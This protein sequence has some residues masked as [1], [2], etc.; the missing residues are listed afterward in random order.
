MNKGENAGLTAK[1]IVPQYVKEFYECKQGAPAI[2]RVRE[3]YQMSMEEQKRPGGPVVGTPTVGVEELMD[4]KKF[5][6]R[7]SWRIVCRYAKWAVPRVGMYHNFSFY[8][9]LCFVLFSHLLKC[10]VTLRMFVFVIQ[11]G[12]YLQQSIK[13]NW[14]LQDKEVT[15]VI[16]G[17]PTRVWIED[18][19]VP[20]VHERVPGWIEIMKQIR[21]EAERRVIARAREEAPPALEDD[22]GSSENQQEQDL[23]VV[24]GAVAGDERRRSSRLKRK[25]GDPSASLN[26][27][28][29]GGSHRSPLSN[30]DINGD[31]GSSSGN[32][33]GRRTSSERS[34]SRRSSGSGTTRSDRSSRRSSTGSGSGSSRSSE[35]S[36]RRSSKHKNGRNEKSV[37]NGS[38]GNNGA[39]GSNSGKKGGGSRS[40]SRSHR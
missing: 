5:L 10:R 4:V 9:F 31:T 7:C 24:T 29:R 35:R 19:R 27:V 14:R 11:I 28:I 13:S 6:D 33:S 20:Y 25:Q 21:A 3:S 37:R 30:L 40:K 18:P 8:F 15:V 17:T 2:A 38:N 23:D 26:A 12:K 1:I 36:D 16:N 22:T 34:R 39:N 32:G